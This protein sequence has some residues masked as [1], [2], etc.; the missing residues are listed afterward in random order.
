MKDFSDDLA[1]LAGAADAAAWRATIEDIAEER[2]Y[3]DS[4]GIDH[5]ALFSEAGPILLVSFECEPDVRARHGHAPLG[6][7]LAQPQGWS[8]LVL[9]SK[10]R[11]WFRTPEVFGFFDRLVDDGFFDDFERVIFLGAGPCGYAAA[12]YSVAAPG[13]TVVALAPQATMTP[14]RAGWDTRFPKARRLD[15]TSRYGYAPD[16]CDAAAATY[17]IYDPA[18]PED[19]MHATLFALRGAETIRLRR[20]GPHLTAVVEGSGALAQIVSAAADGGL[21]VTA[22]RRALRARRDYAPWLRRLLASARER[23]DPTMVKHL[24]TFLLENGTRGPRFRRALEQAEREL[25]ES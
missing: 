15:F 11:S 7:H 23:G 8:S 13:A 20:V 25:A 18:E 19:A 2:G 12:A 5:A 14:A 6:W 24:C 17:V 16:M 9:M 21:T 1:E 3:F 4:L 22:A 10:E